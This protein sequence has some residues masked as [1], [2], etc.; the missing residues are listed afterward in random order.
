MLARD[1]RETHDGVKL[2]TILRHLDLMLTG[3]GFSELG[4]CGC[5]VTVERLIVDLDALNAGRYQISLH[6]SC[7][8][9]YIP[10]TTGD[11]SPPLLHITAASAQLMLLRA[12]GL[13]ISKT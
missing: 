4:R 8:W 6:R 12:S 3:G 9:K 7:G 2:R 5:C 1:I 10:R 11:T 13:E